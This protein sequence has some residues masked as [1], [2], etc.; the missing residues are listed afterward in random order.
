[1]FTSAVKLGILE[2]ASSGYS[3]DCSRCICFIFQLRKMP[4]G[5]KQEH[6]G[7]EGRILVIEGFVS[8]EK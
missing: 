8:K 5:P 3:M 2:P 1:M 4:T 6:A 7:E